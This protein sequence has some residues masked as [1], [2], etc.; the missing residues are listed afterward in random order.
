MADPA[1]PRQTNA[2]WKRMFR[3]ERGGELAIPDDRNGSPRP[4]EHP[5]RQRR[6][7]RAV[8]DAIAERRRATLHS[9][10]HRQGTSADELLARCR[11]LNAAHRCPGRC[12]F[13]GQLRR[14]DLP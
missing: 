11:Q 4:P 2:T 7:D 12:V 13:T 1:D 5:K 10:Q 3:P 14:V 8:V 9:A 6:L